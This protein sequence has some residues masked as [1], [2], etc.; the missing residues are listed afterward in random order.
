MRSR[1]TA[2]VLNDAG[3][4]LKTWHPSTRPTE[5]TPDTALIWQDLD[6]VRVEAGG[7]NEDLGIVEFKARYILK[8]KACIFH[9][10]SRFT[11]E[12]DQWFYINGDII[13]S[14]STVN[15]KVG[16]NNSSPIENRKVGRNAPC[17]CG[18]GKKFKK[19]CGQ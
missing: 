2:Y 16:R 9:E 11:K 1:Y 5:V 15:Q 18:S 12:N 8:E 14:S 17:P 3:Y 10:V 19:C 13:E 4:L 6:V 7:K